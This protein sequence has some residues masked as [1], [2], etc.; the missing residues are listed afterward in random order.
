M[1]VKIKKY[2]LSA[3][4]FVLSASLCACS[5]YTEIENRN[6][7]TSVYTDK[8]GDSFVF[9]G[10]VANVRS[11][12]D[13]MADNPVS[14]VSAEGKN[15][16]EAR[17]NFEKSSDH[18]VYAGA[19]R[20]LITGGGITNLSD[21]VRLLCREEDF[22]LST[23]VF[24]TDTDTAV[25]ASSKQI[26]DFSAGFAAESLIRSLEG[27]HMG[28]RTTVSDIV[29]SS[30]YK[31]SGIAV[32]HISENSGVLTIDGYSVY[33]DMEKCGFVS[34]AAFLCFSEDDFDIFS[35]EKRFSLKKKNIEI[36]KNADSVYVSAYFKFD[37][38]IPVERRERDAITRRLTD[39]LSYAKSTGCDYLELY[40]YYLSKNRDDFKNTDWKRLIENMTFNVYTEV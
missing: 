28:R 13:S 8:N 9:S 1:K 11:L 10:A 24:C 37:S 23:P 40:K 14:I 17:E 35:G 26:N 33:S 3:L 15:L 25:I 27:E 4:I 31:G 34:D 22:R 38:D 19:L 20:A 2:V 16:F 6:I 39:A 21:T 30:F 5:D 7:L 29:F 12:S 36:I 18:D 32:P